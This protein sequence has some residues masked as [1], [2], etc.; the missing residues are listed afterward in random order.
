MAGWESYAGQSSWRNKRNHDQD[1]E[2]E[3]GS[4]VT[5]Q[6]GSSNLKLILYLF[7]FTT[8][9]KDLLGQGVIRDASDF[10][11]VSQLEI[12]CFNYV[13]LSP[14]SNGATLSGTNM[15]A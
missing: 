14:P 2:V 6:S 7:F 9:A 5:V 8:N 11:R 12:F 13:H 15:I 1:R 10:F 3:A 4:W